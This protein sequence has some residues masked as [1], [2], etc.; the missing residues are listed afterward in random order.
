MLHKVSSHVRPEGNYNFYLGF[1]EYSFL[2]FICHV[3]R[4][5]NQARGEAHVDENQGSWPPDQAEEFLS[6]QPAL[7]ASHVNEAI[8]GLPTIPKAQLTPCEAGD[9]FQIF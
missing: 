4:K 6:Q 1:W 3:M 2:E 7:M 8:S 5:L 9:S